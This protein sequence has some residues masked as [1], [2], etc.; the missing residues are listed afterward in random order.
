[1][2]WGGFWGGLGHFQWILRHLF[3]WWVLGHLVGF[4]VVLGGFWGGGVV[5]VLG[6]ILG[7]SVIFLGFWVIVSK[8]FGSL[9][10]TLGYFKLF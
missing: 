1:M 2:V 9:E 4:W 7:F 5:W 6:G 3:F 8:I 10:R